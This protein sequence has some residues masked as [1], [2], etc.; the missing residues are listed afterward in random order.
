MLDRRRLKEKKVEL[1]KEE[2]GHAMV[3]VMTDYRGMTVAQMNKLRRMLQAEGIKYK[4]IKNTLA[5]IAAADLGI[6]AMNTYLEGPVAIAYGYDDPV[7]P[8]KLL[9]KFAKENDQL[10]LKGGML[11][12]QVLDEQGLRLLA[13]LPSREV[14][15][16][17]VLGSFQSPLAG[18]LSVLQGNLRGFVYALQAVKEKR[19]KETA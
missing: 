8:V 17:R 18:M 9:V 19:E 15:L 16:A 3:I 2:L 5:Q 11:E 12:K 6:E 1:L 7:T 10:S 13:D 4:V 14:L